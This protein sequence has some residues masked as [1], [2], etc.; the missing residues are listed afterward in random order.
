[1]AANLIEIRVGSRR[2]HY[3]FSR[4]PAFRAIIGPR[5]CGPAESRAD[6]HTALIAGHPGRKTGMTQIGTDEIA[7]RAYEI[8]Q[9]E[10][11]PQGRDVDHW[12]QAEAELT[13][14]VPE[15]VPEAA[16]AASPPAPKKP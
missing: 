10:G 15:A 7:K 12:L 13:A 3:R 14:A 1:M 8:W 5:R 9:A 4:A 11:C 16:P 6:H 2:A